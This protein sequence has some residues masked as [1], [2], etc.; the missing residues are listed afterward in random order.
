MGCA[1]IAHHHTPTLIL[2]DRTPL[3]DQWRDHLTTY[4]DI[5]AD[6]IGQIG[7]GKN[8]PTGFIDLAMMQTL[9]RTDS[10][11][12][13]LP[14]YGLVI[15]DEAHHAGAPTVEKAVRRIPARRWIGLTATAYRRDGL[16]PVIFMHCGPKRHTIP[17]VDPAAPEPD[18]PHRPPPPHR[19]HPAR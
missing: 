1:L 16:G 14:G 2:V 8:K 12:E 15:V 5:T 11:A 17:L 13:R 10:A 6:Q 4:L 18:G 19:L 7:G 9:A 3:M